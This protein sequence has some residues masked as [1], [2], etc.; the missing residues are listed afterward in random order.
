MERWKGEGKEAKATQPTT[1]QPPR[2]LYATRQEEEAFEFRNGQEADV[3]GA[4][5]PACTR[6]RCVTGN[7]RPA[8]VDANDD[9]LA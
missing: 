9:D 4:V 1:Q 7:P 8:R 3:D 5:G 6:G 2:V